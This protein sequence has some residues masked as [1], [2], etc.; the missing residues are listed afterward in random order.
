MA[1]RLVAA[2]AQAVFIGVLA[3]AVT[4]SDFVTFASVIA[5]ALVVSVVCDLGV[6]PTTVRV[7][8][9]DPRD[10]RL[11]TLVGALNGTTALTAVAA[12]LVLAF[13]VPDVTLGA[14]LLGGAWAATERYCEGASAWLIADRRSLLLA[15]TTLVRRLGPLVVLVAVGVLSSGD[16]LAIALWSI[17]AASAVAA[18]WLFGWLRMQAREIERGDV[19]VATVLRGA[20]PF[21]ANSIGVQL[22]QLDVVVVSAV[23][24]VQQASYYAAVSRLVTP[25][26]LIP[27]SFATAVLPFVARGKGGNARGA[28]RGLREVLLVTVGLYVVVAILARP[29]TLILFGEDYLGAV[30]ALR[31]TLIGLVFAAA[32]S[33]LNAVLLAADDEVYAARNSVVTGLL[34]LA[35]IALGAHWGGAVGGA[36]GLTLS[37][38][39]QLAPLVWR[40][41]REHLVVRPVAVGD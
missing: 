30:P 37:F 4:P 28:L 23:T 3:R 12:A 20:V 19:P 5:V 27:T 2:G 8:A 39:V 10:P 17:F 40:V 24:V 35:F 16:D 38:V 21:W 26:R 32:V 18:V 15:V 29:I 11:R 7:R 9:A 13:A 36:W 33:S 1:V 31:V 6:T 25:L 34:G 22:R 41:Q 14:A